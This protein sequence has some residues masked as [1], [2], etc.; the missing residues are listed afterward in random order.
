MPIRLNRIEASVS[1]P[2]ILELGAIQKEVRFEVRATV[3]NPGSDSFV[4]HAPSADSVFF[5]QVL[6]A[7]HREIARSGAKLGG[8]PRAE[9]FRSLTLAPEAESHETFTLLLPGSRLRDGR[10]YQVRIEFWGQ[11]AEAE[12]RVVRPKLGR[13]KTPRKTVAKKPRK[14]VEKGTGKGT[15]KAVKKAAKKVARK[16]SKRG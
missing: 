14:A 6:N 2:P 1:V 12:L 4:L 9:G 13:A 5:W 3:R 16:R 11:S 10:R 8:A 7:E 15:R